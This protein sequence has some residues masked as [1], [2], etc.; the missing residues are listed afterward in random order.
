MLQLLPAKGEAMK[1]L[2]IDSG[3]TKSAWCLWDGEPLEWG[4]GAPDDLP[5]LGCVYAVEQVVSYG[6]GFDKHLRDTIAVSGAIAYVHG[7]QDAITGD[8][9]DLV[10]ITRREVLQHFGIAGHGVSRD[11]A[12]RSAIIDHYGGRDAIRGPAKCATCKGLG[13]GGRGRLRMTCPTC[14]GSGKG[15]AAGVLHGVAGDVWSSIAIAMTADAKL[16]GQ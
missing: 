8:T 7:G 2:G 13:K 15:A 14:H 12:V 4:E 3:P 16:R 10:W 1:I 5:L 9:D 6:Q 11:S